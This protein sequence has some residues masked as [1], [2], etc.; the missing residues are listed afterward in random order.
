MK[1]INLVLAAAAAAM[2]SGAA[3]KTGDAPNTET[4]SETISYADLNL[5]TP[6]G[7]KALEGRI[8]R[9]ADRVCARSGADRLADSADFRTCRSKARDEAMEQVPGEPLDPLSLANPFEGI[10]LASVF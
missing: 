8:G 5:A 9:A 3:A 6:A 2:A 10:A 1:P 7:R 4:V